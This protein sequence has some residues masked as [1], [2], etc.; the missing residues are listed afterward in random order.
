MNSPTAIPDT[1]AMEA[2]HRENLELAARVAR[3][4]Q[5][6][7][8]VPDKNAMALCVFSDD[9]D[10][11]LAAF[12]IA[13]SSAACGMQVTMYFTFWATSVLKRSGPQASGKSLVERMFGWMLPGGPEVRTLSKLQM[14]GMGRAM[15]R[16]EM[17]LKGIAGLGEQI[18]MA[19]SMG[20]RILVCSMSIDLMGIRREELVA[21]PDLEIC[22]TTKFI[23]IAAQGNVT[24][25]L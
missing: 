11:L 5:Q 17:R 18:E 20:I 22:G 15:M 1:T 2:L 24:F 4:E 6:M 25:F 14:G 3:L 12:S 19:K 21:Y 13:N 7:N 8:G 16:R 23:D 10:R 9:L